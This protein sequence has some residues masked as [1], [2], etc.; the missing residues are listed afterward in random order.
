MSDCRTAI[1][2]ISLCYTQ[3]RYDHFLI[4]FFF[5]LFKY[6]YTRISHFSTHKVTCYVT[7]VLHE[8]C[9]CYCVCLAITMW[10][11]YGKTQDTINMTW[12]CFCY[13]RMDHTQM[14]SDT[15]IHDQCYQWML[16]RSDKIHTPI[17]S[18]LWCCSRGHTYRNND[19]LSWPCLHHFFVNTMIPF[20]S[21]IMVID[22]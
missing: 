2:D 22:A 6:Y 14:E 13:S 7:I 18:F 10:Y 11:Y 5:Y 19:F 4:T 1:C 9:R 12:H 21:Y 17:Q 3:Q 15:I 8:L 20:F 16:I